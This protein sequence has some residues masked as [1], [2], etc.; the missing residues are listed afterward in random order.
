[1]AEGLNSSH[2]LAAHGGRGT[3]WPQ[4]K[5]NVDEGRRVGAASR[6][7]SNQSW[8]LLVDFKP[9]ES[10]GFQIVA[11]THKGGQI[12]RGCAPVLQTVGQDR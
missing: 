1:M 12:G 2:K 9:L 11:D 10:D 6:R 7:R 8:R 5:V 3:P 4:R